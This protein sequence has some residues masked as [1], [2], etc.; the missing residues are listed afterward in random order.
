MDHDHQAEE[1]RRAMAEV[2]RDVDANSAEVLNHARE[3]TDW[4]YYIRNYPKLSL[5]AAAAIGYLVVPAKRKPAAA[6]PFAAARAVGSGN[7]EAA[8]QASL[9]EQ[10][11]SGAAR[12]VIRNGVPLVA[13]EAMRL[14]Q[15]RS[16]RPLE[17]DA[18]S[19]QETP[20]S[21]SNQP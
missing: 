18:Y 19:P 17:D 6:R 9:T 21:P 11:L 7:G 8:R 12:L 10:L 14:W 4:R 13:R 1:I 5:A 2:R 16:G 20:T 3:M 15:Q